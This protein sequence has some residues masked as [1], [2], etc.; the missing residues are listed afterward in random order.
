M[1]LRDGAA[2]AVLTGVAAG[3]GVVALGDWRTGAVAVAV[4]VLAAGALRL[5]LPARAAGWLV[6]RGRGLDAALLLAA[7]G[8]MLVLALTIPG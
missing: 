1:S 4:A 7:G 3:L 5:A 2:L 6:V 8:A